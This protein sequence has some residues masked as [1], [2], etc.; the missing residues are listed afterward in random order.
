MTA[1]PNKANANTEL[2]VSA[3]IESAAL[4][5]LRTQLGGDAKSQLR[6][7]RDFIDLWN[8]RAERLTTALALP[9]QEEAHIVLLSIRSSS[10]MVGAVVLE[11]TASLIHSALKSGD[12]AGCRRHLP[13][14]TEVGALACGE[15]S[16]RFAL[17]EPGTGRGPSA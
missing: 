4:C 13:R 15:L 10:M 3:Q 14:L 12:L 16:D 6:F 8:T 9:D 11:A 5:A 1:S 2:R 7:V 17:D